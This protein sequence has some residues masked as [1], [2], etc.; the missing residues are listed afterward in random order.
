MTAKTY[1]GPDLPFPDRLTAGRLLGE[2][3]L[4][5]LAEP[6]C[7]GRPHAGSERCRAVGPGLGSEV[8]GILRVPVDVLVTRKIGYPP[9]PELGVGAIAR[10]VPLVYD[11]GVLTA[12]RLAPADLWVVA[13]REHAELARQV[14]VYRAGQPPP[15]VTGRTVV[16]VDDGLA[17]GVT[18]R[19]ALRAVRARGRRAPSW[20]FRWPR[21]RRRPRCAPRRSE[22]PS[23]SASPRRFRSVGEW[24]VSFGQLTDADVLSLLARAAARLQLTRPAALRAKKSRAAARMPRRG[25]GASVLLPFPDRAASGGVGPA[26]PAP[27]LSRTLFLV[28]ATPDAVLLRPGQRVVQA[29]DPDRA[30]GAH[31]LGLALPDLALRLALTVGAEEEDKILLAARSSILPAPVGPG[32]HSRLPT[33]LRHG[34]NHL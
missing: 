15:D 22:V 32:K 33:H 16:V 12:L 23:C 26:H 8:A 29:F 19:A 21:P 30:I 4:S 11:R 28:Q 13:E 14:D 7:P 34:T 31:G 5:T 20:P 25:L 24:Y 17:T 2:R 9:Q 27:A 18:A 3:L 1:P 6:R 10:A